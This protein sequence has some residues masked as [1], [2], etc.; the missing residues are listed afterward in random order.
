MRGRSAMVTVCRHGI[1]AGLL[2]C[3]VSATKAAPDSDT[4]RRAPVAVTARFAFYSDFETNLSDALNAAGTERRFDR[5]D[6]LATG[7]ASRCFDALP[8]E[9]QTG[10]QE[11]VAYYAEHVAPHSF[12]APPQYYLRLE[13]AGLPIEPDDAATHQSLVNTARARAAAAPAYRACRWAEQ[14][15]DNRNWI[16]AAVSLMDIHEDRVAERLQ[17]LYQVSWTGLPLPVDIVQTVSWSGAN[18]VVLDAGGHLLIATSYSGAAILEIVF[19]EASHLLVGRHQP[20]QRALAAAAGSL[21][22]TVPDDLWHPL[23]FF[24]TGAV[25][26]DSLAD[27]GQPDYVPMIVEIFGRSRWGRFAESMNTTWPPYLA[28]EVD[29]DSAARALLQAIDAP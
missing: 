19:H 15:R 14:D 29:L 5:P 12:L 13:L 9:Q 17:D 22:T 18:S 4:V 7:P 24:T 27:A 2:A 20:M 8:A 26:R 11:A 1:L 3:S 6:P 16:A 25:V 21:G 28:G 10:W 23:M